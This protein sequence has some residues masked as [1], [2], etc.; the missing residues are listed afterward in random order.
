M[1]LV[2]GEALIDLIGEADSGG[3][4]QAVVGGANANVALA[5]ARRGEEQRFL[6]RISGDGFGKQIRQHLAS[7]G[8]N[9]ELSIN[10]S[11]QTSLA[12]A[13]ID[14][15]GV[16]SYSFYVDGTA[17]WGWTPDELPSLEAVAELGTKAVQYGC[18]G[19]AIE[20]GNVIIEAWLRQLHEAGNVT[21]SHDLNIR[22][23][24]GFERESE[25][26]RVLRLN[27]ISHIIKA[28]D[29]DIEWLYERAE[30]TDLDDIAFGWAKTGKLV[31]ITR[32]S[33]GAYLYHNGQ[34]LH[35][36][37]PKIN[38]IDTVGA[39]DTFMAN[40]LGELQLHD[41]L[42]DSPATRIE[43]LSEDDLIASAEL[44]AVAAGIVCERQGCQ[45][46]SL[47]ETTQR[48]QGSVE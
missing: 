13:T 37:A 11:E 20:P 4:Y 29:A 6:G 26:A 47:K 46:P 15:S 33:E 8:V 5:L 12:V 7:N 27:E 25:L 43:R 34:K 39:G 24:L 3:K 38:L 18:L 42:G 10:A 14:G 40:F 9:L 45:P 2:I 19:M 16:A 36:A 44:A 21:L 1:I 22:S 32:G 48:L 30:G 31:I 41:G 35:A 23:A 28:S 17:D